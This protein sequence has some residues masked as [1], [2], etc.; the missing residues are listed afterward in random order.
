MMDN[1][2][3][4]EFATK[5]RLHYQPVLIYLATLMVDPNIPTAVSPS[6]ALYIAAQ[7]FNLKAAGQPT[8]FTMAQRKS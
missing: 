5:D 8:S 3:A 6:H 1:L 4:M 2:V 7:M